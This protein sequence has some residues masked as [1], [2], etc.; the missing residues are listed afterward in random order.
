[1]A[2]PELR[3]GVVNDLP[4][5]TEVLKRTLAGI[6]ECTLA[7]TAADGA[8]AVARCREDTP[9]LVLMDLLMPVMNGV[10][11]TR[12]IMAESP[13]A[14]LVVTATVSGNLSLVYDAMGF[15]ALDAVNMPVPDRS[16]QVPDSDPLPTKIRMLARLIGKPVAVP[17]P[18]ATGPAPL[19][20]IGCST[21]GPR[22]LA[23]ILSR[24]PAGFASA[25]VVVQHVDSA[26]AQGL[27]D[28]LGSLCL[29]PVQTAREGQRPGPGT[30]LIAATNDHL[31][32]RADAS[33]GYSADPVAEPFRP[34]VDVFFESV[35]QH[36]TGSGI[37]VILTG[38]GRDGARGLL[39]LKRAGFRTIAQDEQTSVVFGMPR[40]AIDLGAATEILPI[41]G[42]APALQVG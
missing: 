33:L 29:M 4:I 26:F 2:R 18:A 24:L 1:M 28:W 5:A 35:A 15:G 34:S 11:A 10:E 12:R 42:I 13:C 39:A 16:G 21:G 30:V 37:G 27:C 41:G 17:A 3:V 22:A 20:V 40:A 32:M 19:I 7:W 31:V 8:E 25:I 6:P 38:M 23:D 9:D 14:I 36:W